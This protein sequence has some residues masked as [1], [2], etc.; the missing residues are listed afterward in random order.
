MLLAIPETANWKSVVKHSD[1]QQGFTLIEV[2]VALVILAIALSAMIKT[3]SE[4]TINTAYLRDKY[5]ASVVAS[6]KLNEMRILKTWPGVGRSNGY[7]EMAKQRWR[8]EMEIK[9]TLDS[10]LRQVIIRVA[11]DQNEDRKLYT[12]NGYLNKQ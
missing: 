11:H 12:L 2:L 3:A 7:I 1:K 5:L 10:R 4:N 9:P 6:N 8:W